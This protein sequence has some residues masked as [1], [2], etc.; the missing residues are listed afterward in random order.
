M[1]QA[2]IVL[3]GEKKPQL[4]TS[5]MSRLLMCGV[6]WSY[7][8]VDHL[9]ETPTF[10]LL[11]GTAVHRAA[12][13]ALRRKALGAL[14]EVEELIQIARDELESAATTQGA[15]LLDDELAAGLEARKG[16]AI[17]YVTGAAELLAEEV[18][19]AI[20]P[21]DEDHV[22][23]RW[24]VEL[25]DRPFDLA[26]TCDAIEKDGTVTDLKTKTGAPKKLEAD[27]SEQLSWY[28]LARKV[29]TGA[30]PPAMRLMHIV[31]TPKQAKTYLKIQPT[32]RDEGDIVTAGMRIDRAMQS[33]QSGVF[34]PAAAGSWKCSKNY[35][36]WFGM[37][38]YSYKR[39]Q[40]GA[41]D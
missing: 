19:P 25:P 27:Q 7:R 41:G 1:I 20:D 2:E 4:H 16:R 22:E 37:C 24:V 8:N 40:V 35:C 33:I 39:V 11:E 21:I 12:E 28:A 10:R 36:N 9:P 26:G 17:D 15:R 31:R 18:V 13:T 5:G 3:D 32:V 6:D 14:A 29:H 30:I 34:L 23:W 38:P